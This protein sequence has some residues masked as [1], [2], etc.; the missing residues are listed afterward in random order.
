MTKVYLLLISV[1]LTGCTLQWT[2]R[3]EEVC[4]TY[5]EPCVI[6]VPINLIR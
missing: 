5:V 4:Y 3:P 6:L 2:H 1:I